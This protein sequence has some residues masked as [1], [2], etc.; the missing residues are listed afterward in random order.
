MWNK[1]L[2]AR[3]RVYSSG[4]LTLVDEAGY[5]LSV[6]CTVQFDDARELVTFTTPPPLISGRQGLANLLFHRHNAVLEEQYELMIKGELLDD[7]GS[8]IFRPSAFLTGTG[9][10]TDDQM[11]HATNP[12]QL[13]QFMLLGRRK[14]RE[15]I[16]KRGRPWPPIVFDDLLRA[17]KE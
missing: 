12:V 17:L 5:P 1:K 4:V 3:A 15:Y 6:R 9:S 13:V 2:A 10:A 14:A 16:A 8:P 7:G 11:P